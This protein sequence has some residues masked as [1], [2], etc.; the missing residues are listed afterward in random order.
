MLLWVQFELNELR[1]RMM[2]LSG[3]AGNFLMRY[4]YHEGVV[5]EL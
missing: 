3:L 1:I 4:V 5:V 2:R